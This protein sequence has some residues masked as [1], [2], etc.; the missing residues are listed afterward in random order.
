MSRPLTLAWSRTRCGLLGDRLQR[1][2]MYSAVKVAGKPLYKY[3]R[4]GAEVEVKA[5]PIRIDEMSLLALDGCT[6]RFSV[7]CSRGTYVRVL[8]ESL[9]NCSA[10]WAI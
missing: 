7:R 1:P 8:G 3:A 2:P 6:L 4:E 5:R 9:A 10:R